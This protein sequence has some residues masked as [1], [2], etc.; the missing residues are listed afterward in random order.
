MTNR[1]RTIDPLVRVSAWLADIDDWDASD[2]DVFVASLDKASAPER[3]QH[4][5][6]LLG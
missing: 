5:T 1:P 6:K 3:V 2:A 4:A